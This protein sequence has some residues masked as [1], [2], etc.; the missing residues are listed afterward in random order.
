MRTA[1]LTVFVILSCG[2]VDA[3]SQATR[4]AAQAPTNDQKTELD[5]FQERLGTV[6][7]KGF[8]KIGS[9]SGL[10]GT[11]EVTA[12]EFV[13]ASNRNKVL[14]VAVE[15]TD[16]ERYSTTRRS[17]IELKEIDG[18]IKGLEYVAKADKSVTQLANFE[19][20]FKTKG[21]FEIT[22]FNDSSNRLK[23]ALSAGSIGAK[24][25]FLPIEQL[26][27]FRQLIEKAK[28]TLD[29]IPK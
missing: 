9:M 5:L 28:A 8:T 12:F 10:G 13:D 26:V 17:F 23:V 18:L 11:V 22:T 14:G 20:K 4:S 15:V 29:A 16:N 3:S 19:A 27:E 2:I 24:S 1:V 21:D 25:V 7:V 6:I